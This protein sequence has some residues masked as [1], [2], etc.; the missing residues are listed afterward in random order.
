MAD[1]KMLDVD[2]EEFHFTGR[3]SRRSALWQLG[4]E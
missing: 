1:V 2:E 3:V 4:A